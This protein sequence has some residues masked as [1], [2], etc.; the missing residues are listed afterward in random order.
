MTPAR[1]LREQRTVYRVPGGRSRFT[2]SAAYREAARVA[3]REACCCVVDGDGWNEPREASACLFHGERV[4]GYAFDHP[5]AVVQRSTR[6][7]EHPGEAHGLRAHS[8]PH[9]DGGWAE[10]DGGRA[11]YTLVRERLARW[12]RWADK[13]RA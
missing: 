3:I 1:V 8:V 5:G 7:M 9:P 13:G 10:G 11:Y 4:E 6:T 2:A 12:L